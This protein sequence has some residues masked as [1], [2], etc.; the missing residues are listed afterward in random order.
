MKQLLPIFVFLPL[1]S[2]GQCK[3]LR[4]RTDKFS[5]K[6]TLMTPL[7]EPASITRFIES[8][9]STYFLRL[10]APAMASADRKGVKLLLSDGQRIEWP[11]EEVEVEVTTFHP[12]WDTNFRAKAFI[13][14]T[15]EQMQH[16]QKSRITDYQLYIYDWEVKEKLGETLRL[17][18]N[19]LTT[20]D[21]ASVKDSK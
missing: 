2:F 11:D 14:L 3:D 13:E 5:D 20:I 17:Q 9:K 15:E 7:D 8:G 1:I 16:L 18:I 4:K 21:P 10:T 6:I 12:R 19:C